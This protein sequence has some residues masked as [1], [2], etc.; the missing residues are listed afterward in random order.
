MA[1]EVS[2]AK[3][4]L[5]NGFAILQKRKKM[6]E[7]ADAQTSAI[8]DAVKQMQ[9]D[10]TKAGTEVKDMD[11]GLAQKIMI[12][13][14]FTI[15]EAPDPGNEKYV[16]IAT[17][18]TTGEETKTI[19]K[20]QFDADKAE[21]EKYNALKKQ[22]EKETE[23]LGIKKEDLEKLQEAAKKKEEELI[24]SKGEASKADEDYNFSLQEYDKLQEELKTAEFEVKL[25]NKGDNLTK[26]AKN[27]INDASI[28]GEIADTNTV[29]NAIIDGDKANKQAGKDVNTDYR[30]MKVGQGNTYNLDQIKAMSGDKL[31]TDLSDDFEISSKD[32][33]ELVA[34]QKPEGDGK[35]SGGAAPIND[36]GGA[37]APVK[38]Q[39]EDDKT[40]N[41]NEKYH[42]GN[43]TLPRGNVTS[44]DGRQ[45]NSLADLGLTANPN[46]TYTNSVGKVFSASEVN[47]MCRAMER[48]VD[49]DYPKLLDK[50]EKLGL[51]I[52]AITKDDGFGKN[53]KDLK[54]AI[55]AKE[56]ADKAAKKQAKK[57]AKAQKEGLE[58]K[59][60]DEAL[61][62]AKN[63]KVG[64]DY[65][66]T[67]KDSD[68]A[69]KALD[70]YSDELKEM[71][72]KGVIEKSDPESMT[73][74]Q[75]KDL[76]KKYKAAKKEGKQAAK[77]GE[78]ADNYRAKSDAART[79]FDDTMNR[80]T[81][82]SF[83]NLPDV[84]KNDAKMVLSGRAKEITGSV[85]GGGAYSISKSGSDSI[86]ITYKG[87]KIKISADEV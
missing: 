29:Y 49:P 16:L 32:I 55:D 67:I 20:M 2:Q 70:K 66:P 74:D 75:I 86:T 3:A 81:T 52:D 39:K 61:E 14:N 33:N 10:A 47:E 38:P 23:K 45:I 12:L 82:N 25:E 78:K 59:A 79:N 15:T 42:E 13:S 50:A 62:K 7:S 71:I 31:D 26:V 83:N 77:A 68:A 43:I 8:Q 85:S 24:T 51:D 80:V 58:A 54:A 48:G 11:K 30:H 21:F 44:K 60:A 27:L 5:Q 53:V 46:G 18:K 36:D 63:N 76:V 84:I 87:N 19:D 35:V 56:K 1:G 22:V 37:A 57:D 34:S 4:N 6:K 72:D 9:T 69:K 64:A 17:D 40:K 28:N 73:A 41:P 65:D